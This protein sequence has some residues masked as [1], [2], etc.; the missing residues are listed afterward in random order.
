MG[1]ERADVLPGHLIFVIE[2]LTDKNFERRKNDLYTT[3]IITLKEALLGIPYLIIGFQKE[4][5]HLDKHIVKVSKD[6]VTQPGDIIKIKGEGMPIHENSGETGD[7]FVK[8]DVVIPSVLT[9]A[10][11]ASNNFFN[12]VAKTLFERRSYW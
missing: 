3:V 12:I 5:T 4:I 9:E 10:Q 8:I 7:L 11:K 1:E 2:E 6:T